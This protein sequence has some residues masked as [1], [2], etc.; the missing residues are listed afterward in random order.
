MKRSE[1]LVIGS[2]AAGLSV[3]ITLAEHGSVTVVTKKESAESNTNYAQGGIAVA[4][5]DSD[6]I[7]S[8]VNDTLIAGA[9]L[10]DETAVRSIVADGPQRLS[11]LQARG[12]LFT[13][14]VDG[15]LDL[16]REGGHTHR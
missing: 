3:A 10:C 14:Q 6:S 9:G 7:E 16:G 11:E 1:F 15:N 12:A 8:H 5:H 4:I 13:K 2:G